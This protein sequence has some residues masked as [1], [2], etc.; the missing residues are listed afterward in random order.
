MRY[1]Q[2]PTTART[3]IDESAHLRQRRPSLLVAHAVA[4]STS[5]AQARCSANRAMMFLWSISISANL[6]FVGLTRANVDD[7]AR[8]DS[9]WSVRPVDFAGMQEG[10]RRQRSRCSFLWYELGYD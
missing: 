5:V 8:G 2:R 10:S 4:M 6:E 3:R 9:G 7:V 1:P